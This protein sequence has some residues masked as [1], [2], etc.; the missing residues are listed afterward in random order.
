MDGDEIARICQAFRLPDN[1]IGILVTQQDIGDFCH[2][3]N[4]LLFCPW[5]FMLIKVK[6][7]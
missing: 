1:G 3:G 2:S 6:M 5:L 4:D 7:D